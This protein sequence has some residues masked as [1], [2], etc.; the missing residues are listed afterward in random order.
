[1]FNKIFEYI[2]SNAVT[3]GFITKAED[4]K[5]SSAKNFC[6]SESRFEKGLIELKFSS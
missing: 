5:Y 6:E 3:A 4:W 1:M 2:H